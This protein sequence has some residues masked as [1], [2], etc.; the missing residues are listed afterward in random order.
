MKKRWIVALLLLILLPCTVA[1]GDWTEQALQDSGVNKIKAG[2]PKAAEP[3]LS[4]YDFLQPG[5]VSNLTDR[6]EQLLWN[7][8]R[9]EFGGAAR[10]AAILLV[11]VILCSLASSFYPDGKAPGYV[12][13][14]GVL[15]I[16]SATVAD[17][18][19]FLQAGRETLT[20][21]QNFSALLL[22]CLASAAAAGGAVVSAGTKYAAA[23]LCMNVLLTV[24]VQAIAPLIEV[25]LA[26]VIGKA[27]F[28][29]NA[30]S[31]MA[32]LI[33]WLCNTCLTFL[34]VV[35]TAYLSI[36]GLISATGDMVQTR[37]AKAAIST[38]LPVVG[39]MVS[40]AASTV[41]AGMGLVRNSIGVFGMIAV[42]C[43]CLTPFV[44]MGIRYL[45]FKAAA[46]AATIFP[47][48]RFSGLIDG[49]GSAFGMMMAMTGT[50]ACMVFLS[51]ISLIQA[52]SV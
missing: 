6:I 12:T 24:C 32:N 14:G 50:G 5:D 46:A 25:Y 3:I 41:V 21:L 29:S 51:I 39:K 23:M 47:D 8:L 15:A 30:L 28:E 16:A 49:I 2:L 42:V 4:D 22:P 35:F 20:E 11:L 17:A 31:A 13:L 26:C 36:S 38:A 18:G 52:V 43:L 1:A 7:A 44:S 10:S 33:K 34:V 40:D 27:A 9:Q 48:Q 19:S 45:L 37:F